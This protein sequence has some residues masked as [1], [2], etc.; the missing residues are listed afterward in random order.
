MTQHLETVTE[1]KNVD[2]GVDE[3]DNRAIA[4]ELK[5]ALG[6]SYTLY[7]KTLGVHWNVTGP[8][9]FSLHKLTEEQYEDLHA[10]I[11]EL[12]E[13]IRALG[14]IAPASYSEFAEVA[15]I[16]SDVIPDKAETMLDSL[17]SDNEKLAR[18]FRAFVAVAEKAGDV[19]TADML[20]ARIGQHEENAWML[21]S[22]K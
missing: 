12:A 20:T 5:K 7:L 18:R 3:R 19:F 1:A 8:T 6:D 15:A 4:N 9:F 21:R 16:S 10:A 22:M 17:I 11:D 14:Q 2:I 13:R